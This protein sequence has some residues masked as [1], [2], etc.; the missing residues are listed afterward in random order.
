MGTVALAYNATIHSATG[1]S[2]HEL[3][4]S[5]APVCP[6]DAMMSLPALEPAGSADEYTL[7]LSENLEKSV[8]SCDDTLGFNKT[9]DDW[10]AMA[11]AGLYHQFHLLI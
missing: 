7:H 2:P 8:S 5:F 4:C 11:S 1:Y 6:L 9:R 10:V 3:F